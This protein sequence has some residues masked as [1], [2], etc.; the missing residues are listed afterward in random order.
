[1]DATVETRI[2]VLASLT[3]VPPGVR[4]N[5]NN[6]VKTSFANLSRIPSV[7]AASATHAHLPP[8]P[9]TTSTIGST[10]GVK[11]NPTNSGGHTK[12]HGNTKHTQR[13]NDHDQT[14]TGSGQGLGHKG[15]GATHRSPP[16]SPIRDGQLP[17]DHDSMDD[18]GD[19]IGDDDATY[20][21]AASERALFP[22]EFIDKLI[23]VLRFAGADG[24]LG[25]QFPDVYRKLH[26]E[27]LV[28]ENNRG[29]KLKLLHVLDGHPNV[30]KE[31][32][33][34]Y[35][36]F[37][38]EGPSEGGGNSGGAIHGGASGTS[39]GGGATGR[40][41]SENKANN[42]KSSKATA[43]STQPPPPA[44]VPI[45]STKHTKD[46][47]YAAA[48]GAGG[49]STPSHSPKENTEKKYTGPPGIEVDLLPADSFP[50][51]A[52]LRSHDMH[53]YRWA[54]NA[55]EWTE[56]A[57]RLRPEVAGI[58]ETSTGETLIATL[59]RQSNG[60]V[61]TMGADMLNGKTEKFLVFVRGDSGH[62]SNG[63]IVVVLLP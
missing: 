24:L 34:T 6:F 3:S 50:S 9:P 11:T 38:R 35:K 55:K 13:T 39:K 45:V 5:D 26:G 33:G 62:P 15:G 46:K 16:A 10:H 52:W 59:K 58:L 42:S 41:T 23:A 27:K 12:E 25:S 40:Q 4:N 56:Y 63:M 31:K 21:A 57:L 43:S 49:G 22:V 53:M 19:V 17:N 18:G 61:I 20:A 28:L 14:H 8:P 29:R 36:W 47:G 32:L 1:M 44:P 37:Y 30:R 60:C 48:G 2:A 7:T 54:G 51:V